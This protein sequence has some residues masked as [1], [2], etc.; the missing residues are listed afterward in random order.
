MVIDAIAYISPSPV[1]ALPG[2]DIPSQRE[3]L[4][5]ARI[6]SCC[7]Y[8]K[9]DGSVDFSVQTS[10]MFDTRLIVLYVNYG[11]H[12]WSGLRSRLLFIR[13]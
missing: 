3:G 8:K 10:Y 5:K 12:R 4:E 7:F 11:F 9:P 13:S 6:P 2:R 1:E